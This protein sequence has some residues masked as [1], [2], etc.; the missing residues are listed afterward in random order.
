MLL[1]PMPHGPVKPPTPLAH[2]SDR[3]DFLRQKIGCIEN[4]ALPARKI[5]FGDNC[6]LDRALHGLGRGVLHEIAPASAG[7]GPAASGFALALCARFK[8][9]AAP[10]RSAIIWIVEDFAG[11][12]G[13]APYGPG[14]ALYGLDPACFILVRTASAR[15]SL[16]TMEEALKCRAAAAVVGEIWTLE[17]LYGLP[18]SRRLALA[19]QAGGAGALLL[20]AGMAGGAGRLSSCAHTRFEISAARSGGAPR[21]SPLSGLPLPARQEL[22]Q[23]GLAAW[24]IRI[25]KARA[26][27]PANGADPIAILW[28]HDEGCFRDAFPLRF[29]ADASDRPDHPAHARAGSRGISREIK[30]GINFRQSA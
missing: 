25:L 17:K 23:P 28:D 4:S 18:V 16:W 2:R 7:D 20:A 14:L 3:L 10:G 30:E 24:S 8:A 15:D 6:R 5:R 29:S 12:E 26:I 19:A 1:E 11:R 13:G 21:G 27:G 22:P 9:E